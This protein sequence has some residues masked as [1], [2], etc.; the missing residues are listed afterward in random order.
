MLTNLESDR[1]QVILSVVQI[2]HC[3]AVFIGEGVE[4][5]ALY[6]TTFADACTSQD[7]Q[8]DSFVVAHA[9]QG[10]SYLSTQNRCC[11]IIIKIAHACRGSSTFSKL[12][13]R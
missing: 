3:A 7:N 2:L 9:A 8:S 13:R 10:L 1:S 12:R 11:N 6:D 4:K 5:E